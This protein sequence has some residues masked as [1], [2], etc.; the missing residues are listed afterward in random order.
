M[1]LGMILFLTPLS[2]I[3][4][5]AGE[6]NLC[7]KVCPRLFMIIPADKGILAGFAA[8]I[9]AMWF[10]A[11][12]VGVILLVTFFYGRL[13]CSHL[14]PV[15][16]FTEIA[17]KK[18]V[19]RWLKINYSGV[20]APAFRYGYFAVF[21]AGAFFGIGSIACR[22]CNFRVIPFLL[23]APFNP[24]YAAYIA[25]TMGLAGILVVAVTGVF[26]T[27]GRGYCNLLCP[28]GALDGLANMLGAKAEFT[29]KIRTQ[30]ARCD[31]C[32]RCVEVC[33]VHARRLSDADTGAGAVIGADAGADAGAAIDAAI[34][35][36]AI[37]VAVISVAVT[38]IAV[39]EETTCMSC[40]ECVGVCP[41]GAIKYGRARA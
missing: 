29:K 20:N 38:P 5:L 34:P 7:G 14:C 21:T 23:G 3:P 22:L 16:G 8:N 33:M 1:I 35:V 18:L 13:W 12:M 10:G 41:R 37:P 28:V 19:P 9:K 2:L 25:S 36:A 24:A 4:Q 11:S 32:G 40:M 6:P 26:A 17:G 31:G 15:G 39:M 30:A 27:G